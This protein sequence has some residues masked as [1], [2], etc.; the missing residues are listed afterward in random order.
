MAL[1]VATGTV[2]SVDGK[3]IIEYW[4]GDTLLPLASPEVAFRYK[5]DTDLYDLAKVNKI[6]C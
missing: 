5:S 6:K 4:D 2:I 3:G 1:N